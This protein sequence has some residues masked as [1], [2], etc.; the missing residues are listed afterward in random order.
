MNKPFFSLVIPCHNSSLTISKLLQSLERQDIAKEDLQVIVVD[1]N[2]TDNFNAIVE[3]H[4]DRLNLHV[5][6][7]EEREMHCPGNTRFDGM[8]YVKGEWVFFC[9]HDDYF[10]DHVLEK[11]KDYIEKTG[12]KYCVSTILR[13]Y[14]EVNNKFTDMYHQTAWLHGKFYNVENLLKPFDINFKENLYTHEDVYFNCKVVEAF[15]RLGIDF[16]YLDIYTYRWCE[17]PKSLTRSPRPTELSYLEQNFKDYLY[18]TS[19]P[20]WDVAKNYPV[21]DQTNIYYNQ[22]MM[23]VL[24]GYFYYQAGIYRL[25]IDKCSSV[26]ED[27]KT[28]IIRIFD[29]F[30]ITAEDITRYIYSLPERYSRVK[31]DSMATSNDFVEVISLRDMLYGIEN[32]YKK[33]DL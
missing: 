30:K 10:E 16:D 9:D 15:F 6:R 13:S 1:D 14:D 25:G 8:K 20:Y 11:V 17:N 3:G 19:E 27:L 4:R 2:S 28:F 12:S 33:G 31:E 23:A 26:L 7:T 21:R 22:I 32:L 24:H 5:V 29:E 18:A